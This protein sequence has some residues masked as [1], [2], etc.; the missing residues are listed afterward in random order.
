YRMPVPIHL[1]G[2]VDGGIRWDVEILI[3]ETKVSVDRRIVSNFRM[4]DEKSC[5]SHSFLH[6]NVCVVEEGAS[7]VNVE[8][9]DF[10]LSGFDQVLYE[11]GNSVHIDREFEAM[12]VHRSAFRQLVVN[13]YANLVSLSRFDCGSWYRPIVAPN[14]HW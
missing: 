7:L 4:A 1:G 6:W 5:H 13:D 9:I 12:P 2:I 11:T 14:I 8:L 3:D 10:R